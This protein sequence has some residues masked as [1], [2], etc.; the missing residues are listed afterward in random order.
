MRYC[1]HCGTQLADEAV[2]CPKCGCPTELYRQNGN[3]YN[4][5]PQNGMSQPAGEQLSALSIVGFIFAFLQP[6]VGL[7]CSIVAYKIA[8]SDGN[9]KSKSFSKSGI[10]L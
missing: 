6:L 9:S 8:V 4:Y 7:I 5:A 3:S 10:I 2:I 1:S